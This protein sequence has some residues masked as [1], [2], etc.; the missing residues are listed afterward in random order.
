MPSTKRQRR[1]KIPARLR[2][3]LESVL[4]PQARIARR[5]RELGRQIQRDFAQRDLVIV[6]LLNGT[7]LFLAD[8]IRHLD[9][10][11][12][13][14]F[15]GVSSYASG[16]DSGELVFTKELRLDVKGRDV[17]LVDDIL[18]TGKTLHRVVGKL[19]ELG[20][21]RIK[22]CV[23]LDKRARRQ[24]R[25]RADYVGFRI[26]DA[27]VVGYGPDYAEQYRNLPF[28]GV[29]KREVYTQS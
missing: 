25:I 7:V 10:P 27:F 29:L 13:L 11:L 3:E 2:S 24:F 6:S 14:D 22:I 15:M 19:R 18:D 16:T 8:L 12:R 9:M 4:I 20:P 5:V 17:L 1:A 28:I 23:L 26:P 21:R